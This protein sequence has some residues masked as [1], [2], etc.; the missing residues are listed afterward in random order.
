[1]ARLLDAPREVRSKGLSDSSLVA[2]LEAKH[3]ITLE[4]RKKPVRKQGR[5]A[6]Q[7]D[8]CIDCGTTDRP[9]RAHGRCKRCDDRWRYR[10]TPNSQDLCR[11]PSRIINNSRSARFAVRSNAR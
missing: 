11:S 7:F 4:R 10:G 9:H 1:T 2:E 5:W 6:S 3:Q 8:A